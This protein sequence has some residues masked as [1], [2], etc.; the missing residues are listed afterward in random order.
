MPISERIDFDLRENVTLRIQ[1]KGR[2]AAPGRRVADIIRKNCIEVALAVGPGEVK[3]RA[4]VLV[5]KCSRFAREAIFIFERRELLR[6]HTAEPSRKRRAKRFLALAQRSF[7]C[8][9]WR[10]VHVMPDTFI[11][12]GWVLSRA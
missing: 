8:G 7:N 4:V 10:R 2:N 12:T 6:Q 11:L 3:K 5:N 1:E 9:L